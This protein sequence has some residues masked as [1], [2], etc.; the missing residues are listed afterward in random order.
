MHGLDLATALGRPSWT[1]PE[2]ARITEALLL[3][4]PAP[5]AAGLRTGGTR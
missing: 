1:T 5:A 4:L 3:P 2:A